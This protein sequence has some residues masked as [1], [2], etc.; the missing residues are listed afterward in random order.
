MGS[1]RLKELFLGALEKAGNDDPEPHID[2]VVQMCLQ[3]PGAG[4]NPEGTL[5]LLAMSLE[6]SHPDLAYACY[7]R[8]LTAMRDVSWER[9]VVMQQLGKLEIQRKNTVAARELLTEAVEAAD[10]LPR[11]PEDKLFDGAISCVMTK[12]S[13]QEKCL[14]LMAKSYWDDGDMEKAQ[15]FKNMGDAIKN[16]KP[17]PPPPP[18]GAIW[19]RSLPERMCP[20]YGWADGKEDSGT[21]EV[22]VDQSHLGLPFE[23]AQLVRIQRVVDSV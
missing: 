1:D 15:Q 12:P 19:D 5:T 13:Y 14:H 21:V 7:K 20:K 10:Q 3:N 9:A 8:V 18:V 11:K 23:S 4:V 22:F 16:Q 6:D 17:P 2:Q